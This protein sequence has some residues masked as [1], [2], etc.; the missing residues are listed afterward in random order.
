M[1]PNNIIWAFI[2]FFS[3]FADYLVKN[4]EKEG[5]YKHLNFK[6]FYT[7]DYLLPSLSVVW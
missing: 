1:C 3:P 6:Y 5:P 7:H 4:K 2:F